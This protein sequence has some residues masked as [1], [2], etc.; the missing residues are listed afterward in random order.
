MAACCLYK[1]DGYG[2]KTVLDLPSILFTKTELPCGRFASWRNSS[3]LFHKI[4]IDL[5]LSF[6]NLILADWNQSLVV[7]SK[8]IFLICLISINNWFIIKSLPCWL[9]K[10]IISCTSWFWKCNNIY[11]REVKSL[12]YFFYSPW[13]HRGW[14]FNMWLYIAQQKLKFYPFSQVYSVLDVFVY[15]RHYT[16]IFIFWIFMN[17]A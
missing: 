3:I 16:Q 11:F 14:N 13:N 6:R 12:I 1:S 17:E 2:K 15:S 4:S 8:N 10:Q 7:C 5:I 9:L